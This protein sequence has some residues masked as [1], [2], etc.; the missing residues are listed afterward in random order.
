[1][2]GLQ[3]FGF[4]LLS[5]LLLRLSRNVCRVVVMLRDGVHYRSACRRLDVGVGVGVGGGGVLGLL[6]LV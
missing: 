6:L 2:I 1:M 3:V 5:W 4:G